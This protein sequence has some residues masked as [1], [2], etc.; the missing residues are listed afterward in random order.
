MVSLQTDVDQDVLDLESLKHVSNDA[1]TEKQGDKLASLEIQLAAASV[2][3][4]VDQN[5]QEENPLYLNIEKQPAETDVT[6]KIPSTDD[7]HSETATPN[8]NGD[9]VQGA[10]PK[11]SITNFLSFS[12]AQSVGILFWYFS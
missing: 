2:A 8:A 12:T 9:R 1:P 7:A 11:V 10:Q 3:G 6:V 4:N 5:K